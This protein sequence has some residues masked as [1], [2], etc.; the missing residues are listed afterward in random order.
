[1]KE[2][3][4]MKKL[5][6]VSMGSDGMLH[7]ESELDLSKRKDLRIIENLIPTTVLSIQ[8]SLFGATE[9]SVTAVIRSLSIGEISCCQDAEIMLSQYNKIVKDTVKAVRRTNAEMIK[10]GKARMI[11]N[12]QDLKTMN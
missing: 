6:E 7:F 1:M 8:T 5:L 11:P 4:R 2:E 3:K 12:I 10:S 9:K